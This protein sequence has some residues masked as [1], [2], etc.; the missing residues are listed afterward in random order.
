MI[1][2]DR[3]GTGHVPVRPP[4]MPRVNIAI[5]QQV[6]LLVEGICLQTPLLNLLL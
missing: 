4:P 3:G 2:D 1:Q 5:W 6:S